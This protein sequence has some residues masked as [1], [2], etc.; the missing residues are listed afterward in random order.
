MN[1]QL[2]ATPYYPFAL[3]GPLCPLLNEA[4]VLSLFYAEESLHHSIK[5]FCKR[6]QW[7]GKPAISYA[8]DPAKLKELLVSLFN[9]P[10]A[11]AALQRQA[12]TGRCPYLDNAIWQ[13][14]T[15][16]NP[17][18]SEQVAGCCDEIKDRLFLRHDSWVTLLAQIQSTK[19]TPDTV[20]QLA[21]LTL[22]F[23]M[24]QAD[25]RHTLGEAFL[26]AFPEC[27]VKLL[28]T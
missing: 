24:L 9:S 18:L 15:T 28:G 1:V 22:A 19:P 17:T 6:T 27:K 16:I 23:A 25:D 3:D 14:L 10:S 21:Y 7:P 13:W 2:P 20:T 4:E 8:V 5:Q 11:R 26:T 12:K